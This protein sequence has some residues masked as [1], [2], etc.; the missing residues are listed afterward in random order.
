MTAGTQM[1][2]PQMGLTFEDVWAAMMESRAEHDRMIAETDKKFQETERLFKETREFQK[3]VSAQQKKT[4]QQ[5]KDLGKQM[6]GLHKSFG[7]LAEH[8]VAPN[9][10][11]KFREL[12]YAFTKAAY[13]VEFK[14]SN[15][16]TLTE[17][18]VWLENGDFV[19]AVEIKGK[20]LKKDVDDHLERMDILHGYGKEHGDTRKLLGAVAGGIARKDAR[21]YAIQKGFFVIEQSGDTLKI[22]MP[23]GFKPKTW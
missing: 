15:G 13:D 9:L 5:I 23:K 6:G 20:L 12:R 1:R 19:M 3:E 10:V 11:T 2:Q 8:L 21:D 18:D 22:D 7:D 4:D 16:S 14:E 17:V